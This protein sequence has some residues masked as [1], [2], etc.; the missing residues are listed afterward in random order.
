MS[1]RTFNFSIVHH[2][3]PRLNGQKTSRNFPFTAVCLIRFKRTD[4]SCR[5][6]YGAKMSRTQSTEKFSC[7]STVAVVKY[8][9]NVTY[10]PALNYTDGNHLHPKKTRT[11]Q[12]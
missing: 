6:V 1:N 10:P 3:L 9:N 7:G 2:P 11:L 4:K 12:Y 5:R 8:V